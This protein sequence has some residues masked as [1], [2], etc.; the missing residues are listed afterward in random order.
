M[1]R[2]QESSALPSRT[3]VPFFPPPS[4]CPRITRNGC[5]LSRS[6]MNRMPLEDRARGSHHF[7]APDESWQA[8]AVSLWHKFF[9]H[10]NYVEEP[11]NILSWI[12]W[13]LLKVLTFFLN[14]YFRWNSVQ[15][16]V[17]DST[18]KPGGQK[19]R[20]ASE[21]ALSLQGHHP[22]HLH[23]HWHRGHSCHSL[24]VPVPHG[25]QRNSEQDPQGAAG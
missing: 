16:S 24:L 9:F 5:V 7:I 25:D 2:C 10:A 19:H 17:Q 11:G 20:A 6:P 4:S 3:A 21:I 15:K 14:T 22:T 23:R 18:Q 8:G 12:T 13:A 1:A